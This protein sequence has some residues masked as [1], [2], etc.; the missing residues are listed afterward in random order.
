[1]S[2]CVCLKRTKFSLQRFTTFTTYSQ[3]PGM[4]T[5]KPQYR[6]IEP[7]PSAVIKHAPK[8]HH[9][10]EILNARSLGEKN[11]HPDF[12]GTVTWFRDH[13]VEPTPNSTS[14]SHLLHVWC[15]LTHNAMNNVSDQSVLPL[16]SQSW[17]VA[18][19]ASCVVKFSRPIFF[20]L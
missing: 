19:Q 12:W 6:F 9:A 4:F 20:I 2:L 5:T 13:Q 1:M 17:D 8:N 11:I 10:G 3:F 15:Q 18:H 7:T 14:Q 16:F